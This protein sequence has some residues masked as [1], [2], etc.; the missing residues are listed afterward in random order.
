MRASRMSVI[1][2]NLVV[3]SYIGVAVAAAFGLPVLC[4]G[5]EPI[6]ALFV[7]AAILIVGAL[8]YQSVLSNFM[9]PIRL[10]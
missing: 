7:G 2:H 10:S 3:L 9:R 6:I 8:V 5:I 1:F 4:A